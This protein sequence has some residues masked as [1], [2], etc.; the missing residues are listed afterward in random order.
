MAALAS[1]LDIRLKPF[2]QICHLILHFFVVT[3]CCVTSHSTLSK[4]VGWF[5]LNEI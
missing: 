2:K 5:Y 4:Y 3:L 1:I